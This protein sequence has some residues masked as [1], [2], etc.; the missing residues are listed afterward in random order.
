[1]NALTVKS[2]YPVPIIVELLDELAGACWFS[3]LDLRDGFHQILLK[4]GEEYKTS[5]QTHTGHYEFRVMAFGLT[6]VPGTFQKAMNHTLAPLLRKCT[7]VFFDDILVYNRSLQDHFTHLQQ[8]FELL[9]SDHWKIKMSKCNFA[10]PQVTYL[11]HIISSAGVATDLA[12]VQAIVAW[13]VPKCV[14]ELRSFL[15]LSRYYRKFIRHYGVICQPLTAL[16]KK[17]ALY[18]WTADHDTAFCTLKQAMSSAPVLALPD[19]NVTF[20]IETDA[21]ANGVGVVL[22]QQGHPL[23]FLSKALG[24]K[25]RGLS[26]YEKEYLAVILAVQQWHAYLQRQEFVIIERK[27]GLHLFLNDFGG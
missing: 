11:G 3:I 21:S 2:K 16:L 14:K 22:S 7:I 4:P 17:G 1:L 9:S 6:G 26:T 15:G 13:P 23:A 19:F 18:V 25:S 5:F 24:V 10:Q 8:V 12:K 20:Q 27:I